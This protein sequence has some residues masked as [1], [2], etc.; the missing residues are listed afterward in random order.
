MA[1]GINE[2]KNDQTYKSKHLVYASGVRV[3]YPTQEKEITA[4]ILP[5]LGPGGDKGTFLPYRD[6][7]DPSH[8]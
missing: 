3:K 8:H 1:R 6:E 2:T 7:N 5:A 4:C